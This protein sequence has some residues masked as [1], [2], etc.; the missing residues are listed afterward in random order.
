[1][2]KIK[3]IKQLKA[4]KK[5]IDRRKAELEKAIKYDWR[6][7]KETLRPKSVAGSVLL[8][9]FGK[10]EKKDKNNSYDSSFIVGSMSELAAGL[11][12][13]LIEKTGKKIERWFSKK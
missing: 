5:K 8:S 10:K 3:N 7:V 12:R 13:I 9:L 2:Q 1:M 6:D 4:E 11:T